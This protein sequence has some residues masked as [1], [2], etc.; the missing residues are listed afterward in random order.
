MS[1]TVQT[2]PPTE[3]LGST[4]DFA[5]HS[6][7][8]AKNWRNNAVASRYRLQDI[9]RGLLPKHRINVCMRVPI[10]GTGTIEILKDNHTGKAHI[11]GVGRCG[12]VWVCP[13]CS[14]KVTIGRRQELEEGMTKAR[15]AG[16]K[17]VL[18]TLTARHNRND[19]LEDMK[20]KTRKALRSL[21]SGRWWQDN[22]K[23]LG[24]EGTITAIE[25]TYGHSNGWHVHYHSIMFFSRWAETRELQTRLFPRWL[26]VLEIEGLDCDQDHGVDI[27]PGNYVARYIAK[28]GLESELSGTSK[29]GKEGHFTPFQLLELHS[30]GEKWAGQK[31]QEFATAFKGVSQIRW[32]KGLR[33]LLGVGAAATD[34]ELADQEISKDSSVI[35]Q[36]TW[37]Q[38]KDLLKVGGPGILGHMLVVAELGNLALFA[39]LLEFNIVL[40]YG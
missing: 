5:S 18:L 12:N 27:R 25:T 7:I 23:G 28:W 9:A 26:A 24:L 14:T 35:A 17:P 31:F 37:E 16:L 3:A 34:Q 36:M 13:V 22:V 19:S 30:E 32:S 20:T 38:Y 21:K 2:L 1:L 8:E 11:K 40:E 4:T 33:S 6:S 10:M 15:A 29:N 39:W